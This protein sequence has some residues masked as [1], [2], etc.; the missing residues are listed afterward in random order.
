MTV[1]T[2]DDDD[3]G[4]KGKNKNKLFEGMDDDKGLYHKIV[5]KQLIKEWRGKRHD[6]RH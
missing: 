3:S 5:D 1:G 2:D 4:K 6:Q